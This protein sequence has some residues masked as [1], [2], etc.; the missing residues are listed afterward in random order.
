MPTNRQKGLDTPTAASKQKCNSCKKT[1]STDPI[2]CTGCKLWYH[3]MCTD[4]TPKLQECHAQNQLQDVGYFWFCILCREKLNE[5]TKP[6]MESLEDNLEANSNRSVINEMNYMKS[7]L[8]K[9]ESNFNK[10]IDSLQKSMESS[11]KSIENSVSKPSWADIVTGEEKQTSIVDNLA[12]QVANTQRKITLDR[13]QREKNVIIWNIPEDGG[14]EGDATFFKN[15]CC[16]KLDFT[17][18]PEVD[19]IR[20]QKAGN[21]KY[22][23]G[24]KVCFNDCSVKRKFLYNLYKLQSDADLKTIR[25]QHDMSLEDR[26][27]NRRLLKEAYLM[28]QQEKS[29]EYKYKVRGPPWSMQIVKVPAKNDARQP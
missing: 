28:N 8:E 27:E 19:M 11:T 26:E 13:E 24:L 3:L 16:K 17:E 15:M 9:I 29:T 2:E 21:S 20:L 12:K 25:V 1:C 7:Q 18:A 23:R 6:I 22:H 5:S 14:K 4:V 10:K